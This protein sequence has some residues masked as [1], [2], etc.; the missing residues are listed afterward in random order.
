MET[1]ALMTRRKITTWG[2]G[3]VSYLGPRTR[4][5]ENVHG[6]TYLSFHF[7]SNMGKLRVHQLHQDNTLP[8]KFINYHFR[9]VWYCKR[10]S[11]FRFWALKGW[12]TSEVQKKKKHLVPLWSKSGCD[13]HQEQG[14]LTQNSGSQ[15]FLL[16]IF[17]VVIT[18][19]LA[20]NPESDQH[21]IFPYSNTV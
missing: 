18:S 1:A 4:G 16:N 11:T 12:T 13:K 7:L 8:R 15:E 6:H 21:L 10:L 9:F 3:L 2:T 14:L 19:D 5:T 20:L 17:K